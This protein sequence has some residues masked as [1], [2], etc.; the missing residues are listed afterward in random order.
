MIIKQADIYFII[1][2]VAAFIGTQIQVQTNTLR[3]GMN[4]PYLPC[5]GLNSFP[6][7]A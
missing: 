2:F 4:P 7:I 3:K 5:Y 6:T 1:K